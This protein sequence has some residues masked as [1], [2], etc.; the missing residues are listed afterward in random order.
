[1]DHASCE[2]GASSSTPNGRINALVPGRVATVGHLQSRI[3]NLH[4]AAPPRGLNR[5]DR[6]ALVACPDSRR[7]T[8]DP[9]HRH[10][11]RRDHARCCPV[12]STGQGVQRRDP[13]RTTAAHRTRQGHSPR[14]PQKLDGVAR[15]ERHRLPDVWRPRPVRHRGAG[16][17]RRPRSTGAGATRS[18]V[19]RHRRWHV[20]DSRRNVP[21]LLPPHP[22]CTSEVLGRVRVLLLE[23]PTLE[24][25]HRD[26]GGRDR[27]RARRDAAAR[28]PLP[29]CL[30]CDHEGTVR[31][32]VRDCPCGLRSWPRRD[33]SS[34]LGGEGRC[35]CW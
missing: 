13:S 17:L 33:G 9:N 8:L 24:P 16:C 23:H 25:H 15:V 6:R 3:H 7:S 35:S 31:S 20:R 30:L 5:I 21:R 19:E 12:F 34:P 22:F 27:A 11:S 1:V 10:P 14:D 26:H 29:G 32:R 2:I 18:M 4:S 28:R